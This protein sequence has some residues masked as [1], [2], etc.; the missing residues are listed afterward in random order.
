MEHCTLIDILLEREVLTDKGITFIKGSK[1]ENFLSYHELFQLSR[2][3]LYVLSKEGINSKDEL[4]FQVEDNRTFIIVFWAC[5]MGGIIPIPLSCGNNFEHRK[6][7]FNIWSVL[8]NPFLVIETKQ[9]ERLRT[10]A[11]QNGLEEQILE[12]ESK[13]VSDV[14]LFSSEREGALIEVTENEI[15]FIQ[16]S[17]GSTGKPKGIILT[18]K[19]LITNVKSISKAANYSERD[20]MVSWMPLSHDM[21][22]IGFHLNPLF[23]G[24]NQ[25]IL[26]TNVFIRRPRLWMEKADE[27]KI[28]I[29][30]SPNFGLEYFLKHHKGAENPRWDLSHIR[31]IY[32][33]AEPISEKLCQ[34]FLR[35]LEGYGL[36]PRAMCPV[37]GLAEASLAVTISKIE[38]PIF[39]LDLDRRKLGVGEEAIQ[40]SSGDTSVSFVNVGT[41]VPFCSL[42]IVDKTDR[43]IPDWEIG[44]IQIKGENVSPGYYKNQKETKKA[45]TKDYWMR[46]GDLGFISRGIYL[47]PEEQKTSFS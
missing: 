35:V 23:C 43:P 17:S 6:K 27:H 36:N 28:N 15:A 2:K 41:P 20:S 29:L 11:N 39:S 12:M 44:H 21:G 16:F 31:I 14:E 33:G 26:P 46:T 3:V 37:Y 9:L 30:C 10:F 32:N 1:E 45:F 42:R 18:H 7:L 40:V 47:S 22:L 25:Y 8:D 24:M 19:N 13:A 5:I 38:D 4:V 34:E